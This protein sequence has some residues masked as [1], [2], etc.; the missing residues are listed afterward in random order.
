[1]T[2]P[3]NSPPPT[4]AWQP[5]PGNPSGQPPQPGQP[6]ATQAWQPTAAPSGQPAFSPGQP[7]APP[8]QPGYAPGPEGGLPPGTEATTVITPSTAT[9]ER[10]F[11]GK[12]RRVALLTVVGVAAIALGVLGF[13]KPGFLITR[14]LDVHDAESGVRQVLS[15]PT[16]GYGAGDVTDVHCNDGKNPVIKQGSTF[17][18]EATVAGAKRTVEIKFADDRGGYWVGTPQ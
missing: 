7:V 2:E 3:P 16:L 5:D 8:A 6:P 14:Q 17:T 9:K 1:M 4:R 11:G 10:R 13:W 18:C 15:D 12:K